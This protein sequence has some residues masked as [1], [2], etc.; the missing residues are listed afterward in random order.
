MCNDSDFFAV[1]GN[2]CTAT[3]ASVEGLESFDNGSIYVNTSCSNCP[4]TQ[5]IL[6]RQLCK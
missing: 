6:M 3:S 2:A 5:P 4:Y 1:G